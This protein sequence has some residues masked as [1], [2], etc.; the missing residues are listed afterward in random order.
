MEI[1]ALQDEF[2][3]SMSFWGGISVETLVSGTPDDVRKNV[4]QAMER[5]RRGPGFILGPSHSIAYGTK[6]DNFMALLDEYTHL[7]DRL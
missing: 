3:R 2:G 7:A 4:R 5:G 6:Y 1:G